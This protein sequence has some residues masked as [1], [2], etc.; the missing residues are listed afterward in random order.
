MSL[1]LGYNAR[2]HITEQEIHRYSKSNYKVSLQH[3][4]P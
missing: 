4:R 2:D 1:I 3:G